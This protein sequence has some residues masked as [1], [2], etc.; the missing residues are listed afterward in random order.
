MIVHPVSINHSTD[1]CSAFPGAKNA[2]SLV[3]FR[4]CSCFSVFVST[5]LF[6]VWTGSFCGEECP[7]LNGFPVSGS[8]SVEVGEIVERSTSSDGHW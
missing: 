5:G 2:F 7:A 1:T 3:I 4:H 8:S 6:W